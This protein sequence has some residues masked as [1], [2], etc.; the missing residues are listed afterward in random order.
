MW[1]CPS[2]AS[3]AQPGRSDAR[4]IAARCDC[5]PVRF[6]FA[7]LVLSAPGRDTVIAGPI[8]ST[9]GHSPVG[10]AWEG[11]SQFSD[12]CQEKTR[13]TVQDSGC[14]VALLRRNR[15]GCLDRCVEDLARRA[16]HRGAP[17]GCLRRSEQFVR[18]LWTVAGHRVHDGCRTTTA[19]LADPLTSRNGMASNPAVLWTPGSSKPSS[20]YGTFTPRFDGVKVRNSRSKSEKMLP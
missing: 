17:I 12:R 16:V 7:L 20:P 4:R 1:F 14:S 9:P 13:Q 10:A 15:I 3:R 2:T 19:I 6:P 8:S 5:S 11:M 18:C